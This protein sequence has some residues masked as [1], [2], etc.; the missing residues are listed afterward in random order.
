MKH[1]LAGFVL[2]VLLVIGCFWLCGCKKTRESELKTETAEVIQLSYVPS[3]SVHTS[4]VAPVVG[5][6]GGI[7]IVS[8]TSN[9]DE[10]WAVVFRCS[11][12]GKTFALRSKDIYNRVKVGQIVTLKYVDVIR[13]D[14]KVPNSDEVIDHHTKQIIY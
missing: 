9:S 14:P 13:Y 4:G 6:N 8:G 2:G 1:Y 11:T 10:V 3:Q 12:H 7:A 5:G